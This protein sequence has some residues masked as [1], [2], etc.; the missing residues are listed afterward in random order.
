[1]WNGSHPFPE[2]R[3]KNLEMFYHTDNQEI[4]GYKDIVWWGAVIY[5]N[6]DY[7]GG[8]LDYPKYKF[9][10]KPNTGSIVFHK[11]NVKHG[12]LSVKSGTRYSIASTL[13]KLE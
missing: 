11:G 9:K 7:E 1:M 12:V 5:P 3:N 13:T 6:N 4:N 10:Y 2:R 8:E